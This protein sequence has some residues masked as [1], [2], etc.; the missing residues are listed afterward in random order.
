MEPMKEEKPQMQAAEIKIFMSSQIQKYEH[1]PWYSCL[2]L[3][4]EER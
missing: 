2:L 3:P 1:R 4:E